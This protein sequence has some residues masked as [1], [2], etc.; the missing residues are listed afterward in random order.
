MPA[1]LPPAY[2]AAEKVYKNA[3]TPEEKVA[4]LEEMLGAMPHHKGTDKLRA[5]LNRKIAQLKLHE[6]S[7][8]KSRQGSLYSIDKQGAA[9]LILVGLPNVGKSSILAALTHAKPDIADYPHTTAIPVLGMME[10]EDIQVQIVDLPPLCEEIRRLPFYNLLRNSDAHLMI[11]DGSADPAT[12]VMLIL[13]ELEEGKVLS[14]VYDGDVPIGAV[15]KKML[16][17]INKCDGVLRGTG[18]PLSGDSEAGLDRE[19]EVRRQVREAVAGRI[20]SACLSLKDG[21]GIAALKKKIFELIEV[22]RVYTKVPHK[23]PDMDDPYVLPR[24]SSIMDLAIAIH[25]DF[26]DNLRFACVWGSSKFDGQQVHK[27]HV[28]EDGDVVELH[29]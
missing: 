22:V 3:R 29:M 10:Y 26:A 25:H 7:R 27:D 19:P 15:V 6:E 18:G 21:S 2:F 12:E 17:V 1:N 4:A 14:P 23:P 13:S 5:G 9:Q 11:V 28:I 20:D 8:A 24:G 16:I